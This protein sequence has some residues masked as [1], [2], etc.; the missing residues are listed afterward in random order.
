MEM[1]ER[2]DYIEFRMDL[3]R[4]CTDFTKYIYDCKVTKEQLSKLYELM[5]V[6]RERID[7]SQDVVS[8]A[9]ESEVLSIVGRDELDYH[10]C[11]L[12]SRLLWEEE[13]Y[14]EVF[15]ALYGDKQKF[16][17]LFNK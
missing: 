8:S 15:E 6:Y 4:E 1:N 10:F 12:F 11:E 9:Y 2:L 14:E 16:K 3:L 5:D 7:N 13:K 17:K